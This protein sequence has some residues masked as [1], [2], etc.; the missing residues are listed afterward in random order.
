MVMTAAMGLR[1]VGQSFVFLIVA[2]MLGVEAYGAYAAVLALAMTMGALN[3]LGVSVVMLRDTCR[4]VSTFQ[5]GWRRTLAAW[6]LASPLLFA[7][8][9]VIAWKVLPKNIAW[10]V[11]GCIGLA[12]IIVS[13][14]LLFIIQAYQGHEH[15]GRAAHF[16]VT[17]ILPRTLA[18]GLLVAAGFWFS[19]SVRLPLWAALYLFASICGAGYGLRRVRRDL[20]ASVTIQWRG[21]KNAIR[22][23]WPF[24]A[25]DA[26]HKVYVDLDKVMLARLS[27][28]EAAGSYSSAYRV[29]DMVAVPLFS[30]FTAAAPRFFRV[31]QEG[32][33]SSF[34]YAL[35]LL[36][37]PMLYALTASIALFLS[38]EMMPWLLGPTYSPAV[39]ALRWLAWLPLLI[40]ARLF[41]HTAFVAS[42][43]QRIGL[44]I[45][46]LGAVINF[47]VNLWAIPQRGFYGA[48]LATYAAEL[49]MI[50]LLLGLKLSYFTSR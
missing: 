1:I 47:L 40:T 34:G 36:P 14:L 22:Q 8:Y 21:M 43:R 26:T 32:L 41:M 44:A 25:G 42:G 15:L 13:P 28:L 11:T 12:E 29:V 46:L 39:E 5:E 27:T 16:V 37:F 31:G 19:D 9:V 48:V 23:G 17:P 38:A 4:D 6:V 7:V 35:R 3:G 45:L 33:G 20:K 50:G 2:R 10:S 49:L 18:A 24:T 30:F